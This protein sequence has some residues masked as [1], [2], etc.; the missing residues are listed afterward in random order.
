MYNDKT[1]EKIKNIP[2]I[3]DVD[4]A[5]LPQEL[6]RI[7]AQIVSL[8]RQITDGSIDHGDDR[9]IAGL[10]LLH[11]LADNLETI[12][13]TFPNHEQKESVAFVAATANRLIHKMLFDDQQ[14]DLAFETNTISPYIAS[15][16][17]FLIGNSQAD[18]AETAISLSR[19]SVNNLTQQ[20][21]MSCIAALATG[22]LIQINNSKFN[23][24][25]IQLDSDITEVALNYLWREIGLGIIH[26]AQRLMGKIREEQPNKHFDKVIDLAV[27]KDNL[28]GQKSVLAGPYRLAKLLKILEGDI[29][30]RA[31]VDIPS[32]V[33]VDPSTWQ[34]FLEKLARERP[35][36]WENH[37]EAIETDF[38]KPGVSA[39][40]TL[41]TGSGK[42]TLS[43]LKIASCLYSGAKIIYLVPTHAL[44]DQI[45]ANLRR[46]FS[47]HE[48]EDFQFDGEYTE[49][50]EWESF[51]ILV[52]TPERCLTLLN[53]SPDFFSHVGLVIF[54][55]FHLIH[56]T[57]INKDRRSV[58][59][60]YCLISLF[61]VIPQADFVLISAMVENGDELRDW[62]E[63]ITGR[64]CL[65]FNSTWKPTRQLHGCLVFDRET[66]TSLEKSIKVARQ[67]GKTKG[68]S[69]ALKKTLLAIP[70]CFFSLKNIWETTDDND[71]L[72]TRLLDEGVLLSAGKYWNL[73]SNRNQV[74]A[75]I[76]FHF[77]NLGLKTLIFVDDPS[78]ASSTSQNI[79]RDLRG[80]PNIFDD[81]KGKN[82]N[83]LKSLELELGDISCSYFNDCKDVGVHHGLLL[84]I[85]RKLI[86]QYFKEPNG[87]IAL[88]ATATL[89]QGINLP[90]EIVI[91]AG[92][93]RFDDVLGR[94]NIEPHQ[95]LNAAGRAGR[96]GLSSQG[97]VI[98]IPGDIV[99]IE[100]STIS[101]RWWQLKDRVFSKGD[102]CLKI[103]DPLQYVLDSIH[104]NAGQLTINQTNILYRFKPGEIGENHTKRLLGN[105]F[106][107]FKASRANKIEHFDGQVGD[108]LRRRN[109][110]DMVVKNSTWSQ[111]ISF[112]TGLDPSI[113]V[114][115]GNAISTQNFDE[116]IS[117]D[118][119]QLIN[120]FFNWLQSDN[121]FLERV[122][123]KP[124]SINQ[125]KRVVGLK[126]DEDYGSRKILDKIDIL[127]DILVKYVQGQP[128]KTLNNLIPDGVRSDRSPYL[129]KIR[130]FVIRL[131]PE[132]SFRLLTMAI[133]EIA[134]EKGIEK[135][136]LS[137]DIRAL[138]SCIREGFDSSDKLFFK[139]ER[140]LNMRVETHMEFILSS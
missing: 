59:A 43:E 57:D 29:Y 108:L 93:D 42:S 88:V 76:G 14:S 72:R 78:K 19:I 105:S 137:W 119:V 62:I 74:A 32:P 60:M 58:D 97:A 18:A 68:P 22:D 95:L 37:K 1:E 122:F 111:E 127:N 8:R 48:I 103:E 96:A 41:P 35:Y 109:E 123:I 84:P 67:A 56:G 34:I 99:V 21:L 90:A 102:Q 101:E 20:R 30:G 66:I 39:V 63:Q 128:L 69:A 115:L 70:E 27:L 120:W 121:T 138:A 13:L 33:G 49:L 91:I 130:N 38:L 9:L 36:L 17:L 106:Y 82:E 75:W 79:G 16:I 89:A 11:K 107:A 45:N 65:L 85:E 12:L 140:R 81:F 83:V 92:D 15:V 86:E 6:T 28:F 5:R 51:P 113:I 114:E 24:N 112:K 134:K 129:T 131:V 7:Y 117:S 53:V 98:L 73:T 116:F 54:D 61:T 125:I 104:E 94:E 136:N 23:E 50:E 4:M 126:Q 133:I 71:Y 26:M 10:R 139:K 132:L 25:E 46:L 55:E 52:M 77:A 118:V 80:R 110:L 135:N 124:S 40:L 87:A 64:N 2:P 47:V 44:E 100:G 31:I 3:G